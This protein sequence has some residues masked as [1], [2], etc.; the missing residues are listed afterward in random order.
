MRRH[1]HALLILNGPG[2]D[3]NKLKSPAFIGSYAPKSAESTLLRCSPGWVIAVV[4]AIGV[5][6]PDLQQRVWYCHTVAVA[7]RTLN[8]DSFSVYR[9][10]CHSSVA[11]SLQPNTKKRTNCL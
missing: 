3:G 5:R 10:A 2:F 6:L 4:P 11:Q 8:D 1:L 9:V 7:H